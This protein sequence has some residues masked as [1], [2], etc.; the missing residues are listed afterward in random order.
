MGDE[1]T[2]LA[3]AICGGSNI[4]R[5]GEAQAKDVLRNGVKQVTTA[6]R[7]SPSQIRA[8]CI[9]AAGAA[10]SEVAAKI[11]AILLDLSLTNVEVVGD[12]VIALDAAFR[13]GPGIIAIS[14]TG[15]IVCG[16]DG[17][18]H[19]ARAGGWGFAVSDE[20][21]GHWIGK[22]AIS[23]T[24]SA[25]DEERSTLLTNLIFKNWK[26]H[27]LEEFVNH[28][29]ATPAPDFPRIFPLVLRAAGEGDEVA[30]ELLTEA[31]TKLAALVATV[32][33]KINSPNR[34]SQ[35]AA[36]DAHVLLPVATTGSVFRQSSHVRETFTALLQ[37]KFPSIKV[38]EEI[39]EPINGALFR[40]R[41]S[42]G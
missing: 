4:I 27:S 25:H 36:T 35:S 15:S 26:I 40:A 8:T 41:A 10:R 5:L 42:L 21:S 30:K 2:I 39:A 24:L 32:L 37:A 23:A 29:N 18:G 33:R 13:E 14:G 34:P 6:A 17:L 31:G 19:A 28:A 20:G 11:N 9:G 7:I 12:A 1:T 38:R 3:R 16:R 22:K